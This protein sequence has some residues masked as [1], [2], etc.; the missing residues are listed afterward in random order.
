MYHNA[1]ITE[2][3]LVSIRLVSTDGIATIWSLYSAGLASVSLMLASHAAVREEYCRRSQHN[4]LET[5][6]CSDFERNSQLDD[7]EMVRSYARCFS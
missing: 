1:V 7:E 4:E 2:V 3:T 6:Y 5:A